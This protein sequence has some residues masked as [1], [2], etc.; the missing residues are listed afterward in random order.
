MLRTKAIPTCNRDRGT[1]LLEMLVVVAVTALISTLAFPH[2]QQNLGSMALRQAASAL[3]ANLR[4]ARA[5]ALRGGDSVVV[6]VAPDGR[7]YGWLTGPQT[8]VPGAVSLNA[9]PNRAIAFYPDGT[10]T[11]GHFVMATAYRSVEIF[12]DSF[13]GI[14]TVQ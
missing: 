5:Q 11:G 7:S 3:E 13:T 2:I 14:V 8:P 10:S 4:I 12:V 6:A 9:K 1:T